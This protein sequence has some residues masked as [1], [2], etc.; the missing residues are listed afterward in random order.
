MKT[1]EHGQGED[2]TRRRV[3]SSILR[4][5]PST[6]SQLAQR[7]DLTPAGIR[8]HLFQLVDAGDVVERVQQPAGLRGRPSKVFTLTDS[9]RSRFHHAYDDLA[10]QA[11]DFLCATGG[12]SAVR[13]FAQERA[14][15]VEQRYEEI[16]AKRPEMD[17]TEAL[18]EVLTEDGFV[19]AAA[20]VVTGEQLC[21]RHC[22]VATVAEKYPELCEA[23]TEVFAKILGSRVQ[24]IATIAHGDTVCTTYIPE[25]S[26]TSNKASRVPTPHLLS[27]TENGLLPIPNQEND[28]H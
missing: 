25:I 28:E 2:T 5:G 8:R 11:L 1:I 27:I 23:E 12:K 26:V 13:A 6:A 22:P 17:Q 20:P 4:Y 18:A 19:A 24:R 7:L 9:G 14:H 21:Q 10:L 15:A 16:V 3:C